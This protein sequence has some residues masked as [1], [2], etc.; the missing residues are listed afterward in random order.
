MPSLGSNPLSTPVARLASWADHRSH[1]APRRPSSPCL[2]GAWGDSLPGWS[3]EAAAA[4]VTYPAHPADVMS[5]NGTNA[6]AQR[7]AVRR[8]RGGNRC[9]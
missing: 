1:T 7:D 5:V 4:T 6:P 2:S 9:V 8:A 3:A